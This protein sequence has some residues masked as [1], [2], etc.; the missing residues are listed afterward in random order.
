MTLET[1]E[2]ILKDLAGGRLKAE[3]PRGSL[4]LLRFLL[5]SLRYPRV[6]AARLRTCWMWTSTCLRKEG[7]TA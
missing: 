5:F 4:R 6:L 2:Q 3:G 1:V 7:E